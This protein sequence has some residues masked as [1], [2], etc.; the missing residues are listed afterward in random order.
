M[1]DQIGEVIKGRS[2]IGEEK[3]GL[4]KKSVTSHGRVDLK[5]EKRKQRQ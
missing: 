4:D 1:N 3:D 2:E 5:G